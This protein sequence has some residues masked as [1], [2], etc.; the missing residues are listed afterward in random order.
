[1]NKILVIGAGS[2]GQ[3]HIKSLINIGE[4]N[5]AVLRTGKGQMS[6]LN[7]DIKDF[8][9]I[10]TDEKIAFSWKPSHIVISNPTS[11]HMDFVIK[12]INKNIS[13]LVEKPL[14]S[15][16]REI[17]KIPASN[18][19]Y[20]IV[21]YNLRF[22]SLFNKIKDILEKGCYGKILKASLSVGHYLPFWHPEQDYSLRY[23]AS[24]ELGGGVLRTLSHEIDLAQY[25]FGNFEKIFAKVKRISDLNIFADDDVDIMALTKNN[26]FIKIHQDFLNPLISRKGEIL[27]DTGLLEYNYIDGTIEF[28]SYKSA[29]KQ[30]IFSAQEPYNCQYELQMKSFIAG[31]KGQAC[32][33]TEEINNMNVIRYCE[34]ST[35]KGKEICLG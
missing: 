2:I 1:M 16:Y 5:I 22:H 15:S 3:R 31:H 24:K 23:E 25:F 32:T 28:T 26:I 13:F 30:I 10:F 11:L 9:Q 12:A 8:V 6:E 29:Q 27:F 20:G 35:L 18:D 19:Y 21:G 17:K 34:E 33:I 4:Q 14:C 7:K